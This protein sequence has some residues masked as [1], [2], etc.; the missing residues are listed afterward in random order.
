MIFPPN[1]FWAKILSII[2]NLTNIF[3]LWKMAHLWLDRKTANLAALIIALSPWNIYW[4]HLARNH[5]MLPP[6]FTLSSWALISWFRNDRRRF[7]FWYCIWAIILIQTNY[8]SFLILA[9]YGMIAVWECRKNPSQLKKPALASVIAIATYIPYLPILWRQLVAGP[10]NAGFFQ[11]TVSPVYLFYHFLFFNIFTNNLADLWYPPPSSM[12]AVLMGGLIIAVVSIYAVKRV[13]DIS[14]YILLMMPPVL[15]VAVAY[16][17]GT[18]MA[19][20]YLGWC[21]GPFAIL[22]AAG[23]AEIYKDS[24]PRLNRFPLASKS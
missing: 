2:F 24:K 21:I 19:E 4:S 15:S 14:F 5:Q 8:L 9:T 16:F 18:T 1:Y 17:K 20:R 3:L 11:Q 13:R 23:L 22:L 10:M 6:L 7:P 12:S